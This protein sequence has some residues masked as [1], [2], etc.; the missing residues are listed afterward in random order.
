MGITQPTEIQAKAIGRN[1]FG[2]KLRCPDYVHL[3]G[4]TARTE[5]TGKARETP[6]YEP[7]KKRT[8]LERKGKPMRG[9]KPIRK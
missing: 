6:L 8:G 5:S 2:C 3:V 4:R 9:K 1:K 7:L